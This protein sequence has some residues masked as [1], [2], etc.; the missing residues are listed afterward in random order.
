MVIK[1]FK[2]G[3]LVQFAIGPMCLMVF[4]TSTT[5]GFFYGLY[6]VFAIA[7]IDA[8]YI[9]LSCVGIATIINREKV[10]ASVKL[11]GCLVLISFGVNIILE[12]FNYSL[13]PNITL[14]SN[15]SNENLFIQGL[16][17]TASNPLTIIFWTSIFSTQVIENK[18]DK[19][20]LFCF[21][22]GCVMATVSFLTVVA[23]LGSIL[24]DFLPRSIIQLMNVA[25]GSIIILF[26]VRFLC[27]KG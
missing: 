4:N 8:L 24:R 26:G 12:A 14:F 2:F 22:A 5:Y 19:K 27:K 11:L 17:L 9:T 25:V 13:L 3:M 1:G 6:V 21:A 16:L 15:V 20:Q 7:L 18:W 10:K 23:I